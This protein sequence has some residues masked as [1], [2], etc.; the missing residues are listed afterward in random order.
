VKIAIVNDVPMVVEVLRR[1]LAQW[2]EHQLLW[3][4]QDGAQAIEMCAWQL[5]DVVLMDIV[6]PNV[7]G[8]EATRR[9]MQNTPCPI[10]IVTADIGVSAQKVYEALGFGALD[11]VDTPALNGSDLSRGSTVL[12][13]KITRVGR[14]KPNLPP[15]V[16]ARNGAQTATQAQPLK[17]PLRPVTSSSSS[18]ESLDA[19]VAPRPG[20]A[21]RRL[22]VIGA[23]AGGP[24]ALAVV[25]R[26][27]PKDFS[28]AVVIVQHIDPGFA[29]GMAG[30][31][32]QQSGLPV[33]VAQEGD[34]PYAGCVL[35][36]GTN[37]HLLFKNRNTLGYEAESPE[38][39]YH[40]SIDVFFHSVVRQWRDQVV[41]VLLTGMGRDGAV[42]LKAMRDAGLHTI[43]QDQQ[44]SSVYGMPKAAAALDA[45]SEILPLD[46]IAGALVE[47]FS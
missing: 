24:G 32:Q 41:G 21:A 30:W 40:P 16:A 5:P 19:I 11:A 44:S 35:M 18:V 38:D 22:V 23:S 36:A 47:Q 34:R 42:G 1:A 7:D 13:D 9:I 8:V 46:G 6:M 25:L 14:M 4:A 28:A 43:A 2:P 39:V 29:D 27:L 37:H 45:A 33:K 3:V 20:V 15:P 12:L 10:L 26:A 31:L 17:R